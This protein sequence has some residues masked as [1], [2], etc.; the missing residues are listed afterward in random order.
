MLP[1]LVLYPA[2]MVGLS[3]SK[4][5]LPL[6]IVAIALKPVAWVTSLLPSVLAVATVT[7][8]IG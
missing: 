6:I 5:P 8:L 2:S 7:S 4:P 1:I 3:L